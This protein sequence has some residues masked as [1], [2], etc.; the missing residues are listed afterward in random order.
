MLV[1]HSCV[2]PG[3]FLNFSCSHS[4]WMMIWSLQVYLR[5]RSNTSVQ[6]SSGTLEMEDPRNNNQ[7]ARG[8]SQEIWRFENAS[9]LKEPLPPSSNNK[10][11]SLLQNLQ[12]RKTRESTSVI[13][14]A[15]IQLI[16]LITFF[17]SN[18]SAPNETLKILLFHILSISLYPWHKLLLHLICIC[19]Y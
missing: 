13:N 14:S 6:A 3:L 11:P 18:N 19:F 2:W 1:L 8:R 12:K 4:D 9:L 16:K 17:V 5:N 10:E 15:L 7:G